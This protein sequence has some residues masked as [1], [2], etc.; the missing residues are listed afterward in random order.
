MKQNIDTILF[1]LDGT[2]VNTYELILQSF[3]YTFHQFGFD[4]LKREDCYKFIGPTLLESFS[5]VAPDKAEEMIHYYRTFNKNITINLFVSFRG[6]RDNR[7]AF[8][9]RI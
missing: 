7:Y 4:E 2:L 3:L 9:T 1:D 8:Q 5:S 6:S